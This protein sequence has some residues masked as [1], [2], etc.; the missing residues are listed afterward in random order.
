MAAE[1]APPTRVS[2]LHVVECP[3]A[4]A[5]GAVA[6]RTITPAAPGVWVMIA[7]KGS[8]VTTVHYAR[9]ARHGALLRLDR[10]RAPPARRRL[11]P[12]ALHAPRTAQPLVAD[13]PR[14]GAGPD[15]RGPD[16]A[17]R[18]RPGRRRP[19][20]TAAGRRPTSRRARPSMP[21]DLQRALDAEPR[22]EAF[23]ATL[24]ASAL[25]VP[26]P[27]AQRPD[28]VGARPADRGLHRAACA[29]AGRSLRPEPSGGSDR[30][31]AA[32]LLGPDVGELVVD[33]VPRVARA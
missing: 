25:R 19:G 16:A 31:L 14:E 32:G 22:A 12:A 30:A 29:R 7:K 28:P 6:R 8:G 2:E 33:P 17:R 4:A 10:R 21:D 26:V 15:R 1:A 18:A 9:G 5:L 23:F 27:P 3:D 24:R 20:P 11:L 13:Q